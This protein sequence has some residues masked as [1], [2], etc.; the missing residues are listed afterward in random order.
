MLQEEQ[1]QEIKNQLIQQINSTFPEDKKSAAIEQINSMNPEQL[2][3]FLIQNN[4]IKNPS[5]ENSEI[6]S[7][8]N[9]IFC[10]IAK[11]EAKSFQIDANS[12]AVAVL[13]LNPISS[14]HTLIIQ[15][16]HPSTENDLSQNS[17]EL[18]KKVSEKIKKILKPKKVEI[19]NSNLFGHEIINIFPIFENETFESKRK[20][21]SSQDLEII[22]QKLTQEEPKIIQSEKVKKLNAKDIWFPK[23]IP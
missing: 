5:K 6:P 7:Q 19:K 9:C 13:E 22:Q 8:T 17:K 18:A 20:Q 23:R 15:K 21:A 11:G 2:E 10:S 1:I 16:N 12:E 4:L 14:G 3:Q